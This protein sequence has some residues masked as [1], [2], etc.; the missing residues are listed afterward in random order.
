M[1]K[2]IYDIQED[3]IDD[4]WTSERL[5]EE[6]FLSLARI[7]E[8]IVNEEGESITVRKYYR[9]AREKMYWIPIS[10][11]TIPFIIHISDLSDKVRN[12]LDGYYK[13]V[14]KRSFT[15]ILNEIVGKFFE[16]LDFECYH[17]SIMKNLKVRLEQ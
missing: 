3:R 16:N 17:G 12:E 1:T 6:A 8:K 5:K 14:D 2:L 9:Q 13:T 11:P 10:M 4:S 15:R 7:Q